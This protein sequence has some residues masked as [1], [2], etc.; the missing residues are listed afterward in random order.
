SVLICSISA[1]AF[2]QEYARPIPLNSVNKSELEAVVYLKDIKGD[3]QH[4]LG[5]WQGTAGDK[6]IIFVIDIIPRLKVTWPN[7][8]YYYEDRTFIRY[9]ITNLNGVELQS[10]LNFDSKDAHLS[11]TG[12]GLDEEKLIF[13]YYNEISTGCTLIGQIDLIKNNLDPN[14][15]IYNFRWEEMFTTENCIQMNPLPTEAFIL[16]K[17]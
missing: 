3:Y 5:T 6:K 17:I 2:S 4:Y 16:T 7:G 13:I 8:Q 15:L 1:I 10:T 11:S 9:K 12:V 14:Q